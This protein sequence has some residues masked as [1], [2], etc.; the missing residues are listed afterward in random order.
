MDFA[1]A[2]SHVSTKFYMTCRH[3]H[4]I[5]N[6]NYIALWLLVK[7][8]C[9][10]MWSSLALSVR[11]FGFVTYWFDQRVSG[12]S[13]TAFEIWTRLV[14]A[15][16][17]Y[18][19]GFALEKKS[20]IRGGDNADKGLLDKWQYCSTLVVRF[21]KF[22]FTLG[23]YDQQLSSGALKEWAAGINLLDV[24][25]NLV[26]IVCVLVCVWTFC[27]GFFHDGVYCSTVVLEIINARLQMYEFSV[28]P[29]CCCICLLKTILP[30]AW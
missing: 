27:I 3:W 22:F 25:D 29:C 16:G 15:V 12:F 7:R 30:M 21:I 8:F 6:L 4:A 28:H 5:L 20:A 17:N 13:Y 23:L 18:D 1:L 19:E 14:F 9:E 24:N 2:V 10:T 11:Y 26:Q